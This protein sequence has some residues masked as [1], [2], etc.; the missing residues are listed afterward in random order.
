MSFDRVV[1]VVAGVF[2]LLAGVACLV[3]PASF[4]TQAGLAATPS[5]LTEIRAF[6]GG[7]QVGL[8][9]FLIWCSR[10]QGLVLAGLLLVVFAVGAIGLARVLGLL[11]D[12]EPTGYLVGNLAIEV[13]TVGFVAV[14]VA[15][16]RRRVQS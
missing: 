14:A 3:A 8:G 1:L 16:H 13:V 4:A 11:I 7:L 5:G 12:Q 9:C 15:K 2:V 10:Q 6:Y